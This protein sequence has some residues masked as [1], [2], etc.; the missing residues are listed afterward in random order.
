MFWA[1]YSYQI[2]SEQSIFG[3]GGGFIAFNIFFNS[4]LT[5]MAWY[6]IPKC[7]KNTK[8]LY[9]P[10]YYSYICFLVGS[11]L[12]IILKTFIGYYLSSLF[13]KLMA[14]DITRLFNYRILCI[15]LWTLA[16]WSR[17]R[18]FFSSDS[19]IS[20]SSSFILTTAEVFSSWLKYLNREH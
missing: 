12:F 7:S 17:R 16:S 4:F 6:L 18:P 3:M 11:T 20:S 19:S 8:M 2:C 13:L 15:C 10:I 5:K 1:N 14:L 9:K